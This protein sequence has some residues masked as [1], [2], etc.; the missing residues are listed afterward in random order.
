[1]NPISPRFLCFTFKKYVAML[2]CQIK[3][4][5]K[6]HPE[7]PYRGRPN[8]GI[9]KKG[10]DVRDVIAQIIHLLGKKLNF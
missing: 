3:L 9:N 2:R 8:G 4:Q 7:E 5:N 1:M 10:R 6:T